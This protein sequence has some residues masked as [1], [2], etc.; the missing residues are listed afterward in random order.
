M[1]AAAVSPNAHLVDLPLQEIM[2]AARAVRDAVH[3][4]RITYS[5][6]VFI[7]LTMLCRDQCGYCT[8]A[9]PPARLEQ[10]YLLARRRAAHRPPGRPAGLPRGA[11]HPR[12]APR[13]PLRGRP[14]LAARA[15]LRHRPSHY[16]AAMAQAGARRDRAAPPRQRRRAVR[17]RARPAAP[18]VAE[19]GDDDRDAYATTS[20]AHRGAPDKVPAR[21]LATLEAAGELQIP[22][23]TGDPRRHRRGPHRPDRGAG[24]DRRRARP[25][26]PRA[27]GH[28]PEL[29]AQAAHR[30]AAGRAPCPPD[31]YLWTIALARLDPAAPTSTC[32]RR[33]TSATTSGCCSTPASTTGAASPPSPP[34]TSTPSARGPSSIACAR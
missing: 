1:T 24:G 2:A 17:R 10:P 6:K 23:T 19:P 29:P 13:G 22:F 31:E 26:R 11:V 28:R 3:G 27:G 21:R 8:F 4:T 20:T 33:P 7:P 16:V 15:R 30:H 9:Q 12:R 25:P 32:R 5:P 34:T 14:R 18:R